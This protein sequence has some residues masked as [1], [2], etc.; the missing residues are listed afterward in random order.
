MCYPPEIR[1]WEMNCVMLQGTR[2]EHEGASLGKFQEFLQKTSRE[3]VRFCKTSNETSHA[4]RE[5]SG[6]F[7]VYVL[8]SV[9]CSEVIIHPPAVWSKH[10]VHE[11][12]PTAGGSEGDICP[13]VGFALSLTDRV[14]T[15]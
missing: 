2:H 1:P 10:E 14:Y 7:P 15:M 9:V 5:S 11:A 3:V 12:F 8:I 4:R 13:L 6:F